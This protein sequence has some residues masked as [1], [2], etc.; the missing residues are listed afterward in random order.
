MKKILFTLF[1]IT[2]FLY[3][4]SHA[5]AVDVNRCKAL[6]DDQKFNQASS[7]FGY[8]IKINPNDVQSRFWYAAALYFDRQY[9]ASYA[10]YNYIAQKYPNSEIGKYSKEEAIKV[11]K[12]VQNVKQAKAQDTGEYSSD[13]S[14]LSKWYKM[15][16]KIWV[17]PCQYTTTANK[18]VYEWQ[19]K[20]SSLIRFT[21][22]QERD[23][24]IKIYFV[25]KITGPV[26]SDNI[27]LTNLHYV[28]DRNTSAKIQIL[29]R[30]PSN[31]LCSN[32]QVYSVIL[33]EI[34]HALGM[35]GHSKSNN[36]IMYTNNDTNDVHLSQ[37]DVNTIKA[38]YKK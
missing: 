10:Q 14:H 9:N 19:Y 25:D 37:R 34:G 16:I 15:P 22:V 13:F 6:Y 36:D 23:A 1:V 30:T 35:M 3:T 28:G 33:H 18:A 21:P 11:Y 20:T 32:A 29:K 8:L 31:Q 4:A 2:A 38:I 27:G 12:K 26:S 5:R 17:Q 7:C 24:Q